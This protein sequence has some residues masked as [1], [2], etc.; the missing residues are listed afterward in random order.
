MMITEKK[1]KRKKQNQVEKN[2]QMKR[3]EKL[4]F[5]SNDFYNFVELKWFGEH[6]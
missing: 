3:N 4:H 6:K 5:F 1:E 2:P